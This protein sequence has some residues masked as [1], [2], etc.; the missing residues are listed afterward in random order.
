[1]AKSG[2]R[3]P[4]A[5]VGAG[6]S[7]CASLVAASKM[8]E[9]MGMTMTGSSVGVG[10]GSGAELVDSGSD[11]VSDGV[12]V[13]CGPPTMSVKVTPPLGESS[14]GLRVVV[15]IGAGDSDVVGCSGAGVDVV[16]VGSGSGCGSGV[17]VGAEGVSSGAV[18]VITVVI[19]NMPSLS[20]PPPPPL[21]PPPSVGVGTEVVVGTA[22]LPR[23]S[24]AAWMSA[25]LTWMKLAVSMGRAKQAWPCGHSMML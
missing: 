2:E 13:V 25:Q 7:G 6:W 12:S 8:S 11:G 3:S 16:G 5:L 17:L 19:V 9:K 4:P 14:E 21:L 22:P 20:P 18:L 10:A 23:I 1:V 24:S 15:G